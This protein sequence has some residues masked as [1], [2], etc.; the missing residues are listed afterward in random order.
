MTGRK[1]P[2]TQHAERGAWAHKPCSLQQGGLA[3][4]RRARLQPTA[5]LWLCRLGCVIMCEDMRRAGQATAHAGWAALPPADDR[6]SWQRLLSRGA[7]AGCCQPPQAVATKGEACSSRCQGPTPPKCACSSLAGTRLCSSCAATMHWQEQ[8]L[9]NTW[10][11]QT[12][13]TRTTQRRHNEW[14]RAPCHVAVEAAVLHAAPASAACWPPGKRAPHS[15]W[16]GRAATCEKRPDPLSCSHAGRSSQSAV[17]T[18]CAPGPFLPQD[19]C[20]SKH[21]RNTCWHV[22]PSDSLV[23]RAQASATHH[24]NSRVRVATECRHHLSGVHL[25]VLAADGAAHA[26]VTV[27][28]AAAQRAP[29]ADGAPLAAE[30]APACA[31]GSMCDASRRPATLLLP[32]VRHQLLTDVRELPCALC[33]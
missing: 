25:V 19:F 27:A 26:P 33:S 24:H 8:P 16:V 22:W 21:L 14:L 9:R 6:H 7:E 20:L 32:W 28:V 4:G 23:H 29:P 3:A 2:R 18:A 10:L 15:W 31:T 12:S 13:N 11:C 30:G 17:A 1:T 5:R